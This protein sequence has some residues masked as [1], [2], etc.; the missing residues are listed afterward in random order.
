LIKVNLAGPRRPGNPRTDAGVL[1]ALL[2]LI[3]ETGARCAVAEGAYGYLAENLHAIGLGPVLKQTQTQ[4]I[5]LDLEE[6]EEVIINGEAHYIPRCLR[7]YTV[8]LAVPAA[9]KR[10]EMLFS[11]NVK[12]FVG[13]V[14]RR[15][16]QLDEPTTWRPRLHVDLHRSVANVF[17][18]VQQYAPFQYFINGGI[19]AQEGRGE[20]PLPGVLVGDDALELDEYLIRSVFMIDQPEYLRLLRKNTL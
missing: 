19:M 7:E 18:A 1:T 20:F 6:A 3:T 9:T 11:N 15:Y 14:P 13:T 2:H 17:L 16:Y 4:V 8:R 12:L 10:E 5:D